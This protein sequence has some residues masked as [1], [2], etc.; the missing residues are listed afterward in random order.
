MKHSLVFHFIRLG[1]SIQ[2]TIDFKSP[3][4]SLSYSQAAALLAI[5]QEKQLSQ[6]EIATRLHLEPAS[7]VTLIDELERL[8]LAKRHL[9]GQD[10]RKYDIGLTTKGLAK[11]NLIQQKV[12]SLDKEIAASLANSQSQSLAESIDSITYYL[13]NKK[14]GEI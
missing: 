14:G 10:R 5:L 8:G 4:F 13:E 11:A 6:R 9:H 7:V 3:P 12:Y 1:K 2:K